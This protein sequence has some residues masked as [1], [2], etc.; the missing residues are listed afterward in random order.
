[1]H[2]RVSF[3]LAE[4]AAVALAELMTAELGCLSASKLLLLLGGKLETGG[5][6]CLAVRESDCTR[7]VRGL[8]MM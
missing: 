4:L 1:M 7:G 2:I 5:F 6:V 3:S 8:D